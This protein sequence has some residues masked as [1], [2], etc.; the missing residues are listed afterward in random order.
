MAFLRESG[1]LLR[2][3]L[4]TFQKM[5]KFRNV[6]FHDYARI[7]PEILY[8]NSFWLPAHKQNLLPACWQE[9]SSITPGTW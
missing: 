4:D 8:A 2:E 5:A 7:D 6:I 9:A 1:Y 3:K